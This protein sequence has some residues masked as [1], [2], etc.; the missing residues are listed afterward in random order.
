M[1]LLR[2]IVNALDWTKPIRTAVLTDIYA[3]DRPVASFSLPQG[4]EW[5]VH[6]VQALL[7]R[8]GIAAWGDIYQG[9]AVAFLVRADRAAEATRV[10]RQ[11]GIATQRGR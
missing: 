5:T 7:R 8:N 9:N 11:A 3:S 1:G 2:E 4:G 6:Q 10:M